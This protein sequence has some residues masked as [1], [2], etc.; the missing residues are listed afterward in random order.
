MNFFEGLSFFLVLFA[1]LIPAFILG[2]KEK[3]I[4]QYALGFS[5]FFLYL[6]CR[7]SMSGFLYLIAFYVIEWYVIRIYLFL[8]KKYG[9]N[10]SLYVQF[11]ILAMLPLILCKVSSLVQLNLFAFIGVSYVSFKVIQIVIETYDGLI[12]E[13]S[14]FEY[15]SFIL[16]FPSISSGPIDRSRR[17]LSDLHN[18]PAKSE[19]LRMAGEGIFKLTLGILYKFAL[20][21]IA[22]TLMNRVSNIYAPLEVI[23][24]AYLYGIYMFF[25]FAGYSNMAIGASYI[26]GI[27]TPENFNKPFLSIDIK[28]FW[29]RWHM[30]LS[31]WFRD[32]V[33]SRFMLDSVRKKRFS[34][35]LNLAFSAYMVNMSIMGFWHGITPSY[36]LYG[37]YHGLLLGGFEFYQKK[38]KFYKNNKNKKWYKLLSWFVTLNLIMFG[39]LIFS[40]H[41][42]EI[43]HRL[44]RLLLLHI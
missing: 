32:F 18:I 1:G 31:Y 9:K 16:F 24:Y 11:V 7:N 14:F 28:D 6:I 34:S 12:E 25:D 21:G 41:F 19:Y 5:I 39:F 17:Y 22:F 37:L 15:S 10:S 42:M 4:K 36:I 35:K 8:R 13:M 20:G 3:P 29:N 23:A 2:V 44:V 27:K 26:L 40:G 33:F 43:V 38:S 30:T